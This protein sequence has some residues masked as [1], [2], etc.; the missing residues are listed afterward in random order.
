[1]DRA[2]FAGTRGR[3]A[4]HASA[5][6]SGGAA[7]TAGENRPDR[8]RLKKAVERLDELHSFA[9]APLPAKTMAELRRLMARHRLLCEQ[10]REIEAEPRSGGNGAATGPGRAD[11]PC[12]RARLGEIYSAA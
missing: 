5:E 7:R 12:G 2:L 3:G 4:G 11:D 8:P 1:L 10:L 6:H 9:G